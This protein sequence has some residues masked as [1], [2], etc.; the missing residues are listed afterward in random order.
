VQNEDSEADAVRTDDRGTAKFQ[1]S[2]EKA[3]PVTPAV[4]VTFI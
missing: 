1:F 4:Y 2:S 3:A